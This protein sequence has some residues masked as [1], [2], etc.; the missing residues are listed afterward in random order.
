MPRGTVGVPGL[1]QCR[2]VSNAYPQ[3]TRFGE[4]MM[5]KILFVALAIAGIS[6]TIVPS[7]A[8]ALVGWNGFQ[9]ANGMVLQNGA[10]FANGADL[11]GLSLEGVI[12]PESAE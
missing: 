2:F 11:G 12:L 4:T 6:S 7:Q 9:L 5:K 1:G 8:L 3:A 10:N